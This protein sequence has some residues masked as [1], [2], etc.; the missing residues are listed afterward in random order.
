M[1]QPTAAM[2]NLCFVIHGVG[3]HYSTSTPL[4]VEPVLK[5]LGHFH[6]ESGATPVPLHIQFEA[7]ESR[8]KIPVGIPPS[9][10]RLS[11]AE[12]SSLRDGARTKWGCVMVQDGPRLI[13]DFYDDGLIVIDLAKH[14]AEGYLVRPQES[15]V[16]TVE[17]YLHFALVELLKLR[18]LFTLHATAL[19]KNGY[20]V[21]IPG[22]SGRGKTT[23]FVALLR[24]GYRYLADDTPFL[25]EDGRGVR[26]LSFPMKVD[27]T[28]STISFF[29]ELRNAPR[30]V[31]RSGVHK[32]YFF[33]EDVYPSGI[34]DSCPPALILFPRVM[35]RP[36]SM[37]EPLPKSRAIE[38]MM[39]QAL[40]V[41]DQELARQEFQVLSKLVQQ[42]DCYTLHFGHDVLELPDLVTPLLEGRR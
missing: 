9:A 31:L 8:E 10:R 27:V 4:L 5:L 29:P 13:A 7:V 23:S 11:T 32:K 1:T 34:T 40:L 16:G 3:L 2:T 36:K 42:A 20:G 15:P 37:L 6:D 21:L 22:Y 17:W 12:G 38:A 25:R 39:P 14:I 33:V 24:S 18:G 41:H 30:G 19:E 35:D 26:I 28:D